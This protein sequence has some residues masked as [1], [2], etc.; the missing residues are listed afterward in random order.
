MQNK[1][2]EITTNLSMVH[3]KNHYYVECLLN[4]NQTLAIFSYK[5]FT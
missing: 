5:Q 1:I 3:K 4:K 2:K